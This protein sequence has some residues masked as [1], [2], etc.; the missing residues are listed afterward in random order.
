MAIHAPITGAP[1]RASLIQFRLTEESRLAIENEIE[2][3]IALLDVED[4]DCDL[5]DGDSDMAA[6]DAGEIEDWR[7]D[8]VLLPKPIYGVDQTR[9]P[10]NEHEMHEA[11]RA[12]V[13]RNY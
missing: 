10:L 9:G 6:D 3:L 13:Q 7:P 11:W 2:R 4:G 1:L 12:A 8:G 5:E